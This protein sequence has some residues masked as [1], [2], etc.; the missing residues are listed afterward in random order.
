MHAVYFSRIRSFAVGNN[1]QKKKAA[2]D[3]AAQTKHLAISLKRKLWFCFRFLLSSL[4]IT[5]PVVARQ[6]FGAQFAKMQL[7]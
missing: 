7:P 3:G 4:L 1:I 6:A 5:R 2:T